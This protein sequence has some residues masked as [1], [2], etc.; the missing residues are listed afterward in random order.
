MLMWVVRIVVFAGSL[1]LLGGIAG[2]QSV[3]IQNKQPKRSTTNIYADR[4]MWDAAISAAINRLHQRYHRAIVDLQEALQ[5]Q[6]SAELYYLLAQ[7]YADI[8]K[9]SQALTA[10]RQALRLDPQFEPA[11]A[12]LGELFIANGQLDSALQVYRVLYQRKPHSLQ[13]GY[14]LGRLYEYRSPDSAIALYERLL[15]Q[16][17]HSEVIRRLVRLYVQRN[18]YKHAWHYLRRFLENNPTSFPMATAAIELAVQHRRF[19]DAYQQLVDE[20]FFLSREQF[21]SHFAY[22]CYHWL[23]ADTVDRS[24]LPRLWQLAR[25]YPEDWNVQYLCGALAIATDADSVGL[26]F[27]E[28]AL[29]AVDTPATRPL[30]VAALLFDHHRYLP[31]IAILR[32]YMRCYPQDGRYPAFIAAHYVQ[33]KQYDSALVYAKQA[34]SIDSTDAA[35]W[36]QLGIVY[37]AMKQRDSSDAAYA[38]AL[39]LDSSDAVAA[40]NLAYSYAEQGIHLDVALRLAQ[41]AIAADSTNASFLDT[42]GWVYFKL[43]Q[44]DKAVQ[45]LEKARAAGDPS[46]VILEHLGDVYFQLG[47]YRLARQMWEQALQLDPEKA[48]IKERLENVDRLLQEAGR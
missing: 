4:R 31:A 10:V 20:E 27:L 3:Q 48:S 28:Q 30:Q 32:R 39:A 36:T 44:Y 40:N 13:Y 11:L 25:Y 23:D 6:Q 1:V 19:R 37:G 43:G 26:P 29:V 8:D 33:L 38:R 46:A 7:N 12:L 14:L 41:R 2:C 15:Q 22:V 47:R 16:E 35:S 34:V 45:W 24:V 5:Y 18:D 17:D 9:T 42:I 21:L